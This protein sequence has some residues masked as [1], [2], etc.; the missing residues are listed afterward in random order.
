MTTD[1]LSFDSE[2]RNLRADWT[3]VKT[4]KLKVV[5]WNNHAQGYVACPFNAFFGHLVT[6]RSDSMI[7]NFIFTELCTVLQ[8]S[9][10]IGETYREFYSDVENPFLNDVPVGITGSVC[11]KH[12]HSRTHTNV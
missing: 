9:T 12:G 11:S 10:K 1:H 5:F 4:G 8:P 3:Q 6:S 7:Q 2:F